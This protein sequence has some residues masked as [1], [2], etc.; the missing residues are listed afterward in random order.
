[1]E[2]PDEV[3][4]NLDIEF[5]RVLSTAEVAAAVDRLETAIRERHPD[6]KRIFIEAERLTGALRQE[7]LMVGTTYPAGHMLC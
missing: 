6:M 5:R 1:M 3:L 4:L 2:G 7:R